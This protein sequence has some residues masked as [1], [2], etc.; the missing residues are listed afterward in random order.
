MKDN[1]GMFAGIERSTNLIMVRISSFS[2]YEQLL[3]VSK[4]PNI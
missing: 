2:L 4:S 1:N 3:K